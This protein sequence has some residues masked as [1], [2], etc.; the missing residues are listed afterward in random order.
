MSESARAEAFASQADRS[1]ELAAGYANQMVALLRAVRDLRDG[2][3]SAIDT[4]QI[5]HRWNGTMLELYWEGEWLTGPDLAGKDARGIDSIGIVDGRVI[6]TYDDAE[7]EDIGGSAGD[8]AGPA[9]SVGE[10]LVAFNGTSGKAL[11][12]SGVA[13]STD[14]TLAGNSD[15][16][17]PTQKAVKT[18]IDALAA[19]VPTLDGSGKIVTS[20]L[21]TLAITDVFAVANEAA[22]LALTA[23]RGD[24]AVRSD[25]NKSYVLS[26]D[27]P[28][29]L[30]NWV[31]LRT[32]TDA[33][34]SVN[35]KTGA[36]VLNPDDLS[37]ASTTN[38]FASATNIA[39]VM[40]GAS[41]KTTPVDADQLGLI[42]SAA[43]NV[44]KKLTWANLK[45]TLKATASA[46]W[47]G[48]SDSVFLTPA[49][50]IASIIP[51]KN[52]SVTGSFTP[53]FSAAFNFEWTFT[54]NVTL[55][56]PTGM[57][58]GQSGTIYIIQDG[59][60][61]RTLSLNASIKKP[62]GTAPTLST[63]ASSVDR[64]GYIVRNVGGTMQLELTSLERGIA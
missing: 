17:I 21:P 34:L 16:A 2:T 46:I 45:A 64:F 24:V 58:E 28:T 37:D 52:T 4:M 43:S 20:F 31:L 56:V 7:T 9:S 19:T 32:P 26:T 12:D 27:D 63:A 60:G 49:S 42:D 30:A 14:G 54:G 11:K 61:S 50:L 13:V 8:V 33:V 51:A 1:R 15:A 41:G 62:G 57:R 25:E 35:T 39:A 44:L 47:A 59:T 23:Q 38:K 40:T 29:I 53:D 6:V 18:K 3:V 5:P 22:M 36:V 55:N 10:N 48:T